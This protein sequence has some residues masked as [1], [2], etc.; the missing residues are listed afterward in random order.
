MSIKTIEVVCQPCHK[1]EFIEK[2]I[3]EALRSLEYEYK[4][5][6]PVEIKHSTNIKEIVG[7]FSLYASQTPVVLINGSVEFAGRIEAAAIR[8]KL[9]QIHKGY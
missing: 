5:K 7:K 1:C 9:D 4:I 3:L 2:K 6:I 8:F